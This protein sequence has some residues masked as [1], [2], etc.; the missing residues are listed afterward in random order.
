VL[1]LG[2]ALRV[3][4]LHSEANS[5]G[6]GSS[7]LVG[8][9]DTAIGTSD[10][11]NGACALTVDPLLTLLCLTASGGHG[12]AA[13]SV[14]DLGVG[15]GALTG[16]AFGTK[17]ASAA[18]P[19]A[20]TGPVATPEAPGAPNAP[21]GP[22]VS[23]TESEPA[24]ALGTEVALGSPSAGSLPRTGSDATRQVAAGFALLMLG[25]AVSLLGRAR[26]VL[27]LPG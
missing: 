2:D 12:L 23:G 18:A 15:G 25:A 21:T 19:T 16:T 22:V 27:P 11:A 8:L 7:Y 20:P 5:E 26:R 3:V 17:A 6:T 1:S 14:A 13:A 4:L 10:Q 9:N 24:P